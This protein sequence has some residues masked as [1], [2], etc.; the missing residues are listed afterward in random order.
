MTDIFRA[1]PRRRSR[2]IVWLASSTRSFA[3]ALAKWTRK[4]SIW[5]SGLNL[6]SRL[7]GATGVFSSTSPE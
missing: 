4:R 6:G 1:R 3:L 2:R 7:N 5:L